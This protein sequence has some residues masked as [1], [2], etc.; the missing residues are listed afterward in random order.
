VFK[1]IVE[2]THDHIHTR[3]VQ[4]DP[5]NPSI[6][7]LNCDAEHLAFVVNDNNMYAKRANQETGK[8]EPITREM[9]VSIV[10]D[11]KKNAQVSTL[12]PYD[13]FMSMWC[14]VMFFLFTN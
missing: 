1:G 7:D 2:G 6:F 13:M 10:E 3:W 9:F 4:N 14:H 11:V 5:K 12:N 8:M